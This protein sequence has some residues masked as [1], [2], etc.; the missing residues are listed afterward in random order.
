ME[1]SE[2]KAAND[3]EPTLKGKWVDFSARQFPDW[4]AKEVQDLLGDP[5][6]YVIDVLAVT[7]QEEHAHVIAAKDVERYLQH[8]THMPL[9]VKYIPSR[10]LSRRAPPLSFIE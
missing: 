4:F 6:Y 7:G 2:L 9:V 8:G 5:P 3:N 1:K 10:A